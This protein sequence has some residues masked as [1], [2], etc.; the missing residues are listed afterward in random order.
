MPYKNTKYF[1]NKKFRLYAVFDHIARQKSVRNSIFLDYANIRSIGPNA[2]GECAIYVY[3]HTWA[4]K[5]SYREYPE[6]PFHY[7]T[8]PFCKA[9]GLEKSIW[10]EIC[11]MKPY[12][13]EN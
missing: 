5:G 11:P 8:D 2:K 9:D 10:N 3:N 1:G 13:S 7:S 4:A 12:V 6:R